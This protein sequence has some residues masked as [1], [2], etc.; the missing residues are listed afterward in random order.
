MEVRPLMRPETEEKTL[1][2]ARYIVRTGATV[3]QAAAAFHMSKSAVHKLMRG[4]LKDLHPG[5]Y[6]EVSRLLDYHREIKHLRGGEA[7]RIKYCRL[8]QDNARA[9]EKNR[10]NP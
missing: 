2:L 1:L 3:R 10:Q 6:R 8:R 4:A 9:I 5:L 7:T